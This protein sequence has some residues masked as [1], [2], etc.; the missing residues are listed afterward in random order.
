SP[1]YTIIVTALLARREVTATGTLAHSSRA[2]CVTRATVAA[3]VTDP[4]SSMAT[5]VTWASG[6]AVIHCS[7]AA[8]VAAALVGN[9]RPAVNPGVIPLGTAP[10]KALSPKLAATTD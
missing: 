5:W 7:R 2:T 6:S 3:L 8:C 1:T 9:V 10:V 4:H